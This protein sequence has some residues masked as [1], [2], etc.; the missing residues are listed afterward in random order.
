MTMKPTLEKNLRIEDYHNNR[1]Y[2]SKSMLSKIDDCPARFNYL[3]NEGGAPKATPSLR[4][5][6]AIHVLALE[7]KLW[8]SGYHVTPETYFDDKGKEKP[9]RNDKR[10]QVYKDEM[11][12]AGDKIMLSH[13]DYKTVETMANA[14]AKNNFACSLLKPKGYVESSIF[15]KDEETGLKLKCRPDL[16]RN[17]SLIVDLKMARSVKPA[18]FNKD[19][20]NF[21][22][23]ISVA[24]TARGYKALYG[25]EPDNYVF[26]CIEPEAPHIIECFE[27]YQ[28]MDGSGLSYK[29]IG[30]IRLSKLLDTYKKCKE[31]GKW[32]AYQ[33]KIGTMRAP[34]WAVKQ[35]I[36]GEENE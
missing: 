27:S 11:E 32:P 1:E 19:A 3:F 25:K 6:N 12:K 26:L 20:F 22:Y 23:D 13:D 29:D 4:M 18:F 35:I 36:E 9:W 17:D 2:L 7:P 28:P 33:D 31:S 34:H 8:K 21:R 14:L 30:E 16:M 24:L 10:M 15:W 5:G